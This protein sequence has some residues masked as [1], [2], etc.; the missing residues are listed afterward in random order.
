MSCKNRHGYPTH[1]GNKLGKINGKIIYD[2]SSGGN[3]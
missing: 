2:I 1:F 3:V